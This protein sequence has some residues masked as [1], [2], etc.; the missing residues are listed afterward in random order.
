MLTNLCGLLLSTGDEC[1]IGV[2]GSPELAVANQYAPAPSAA[3]T[4]TP[5]RTARGCVTPRQYGSEP[6]PLSPFCYAVSM[7]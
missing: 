2:P 4:K 1:R 3:A 5:R 6:S 7:R